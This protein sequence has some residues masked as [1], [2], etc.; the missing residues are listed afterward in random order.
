MDRYR[1]IASIVVLFIYLL[2]M[3]PLPTIIGA[4]VLIIAYV[5]ISNIGNNPARGIGR[6]IGKIPEAQE[7][8]RRNA[9]K[10]AKIYL[11]PYSDIW[12]NLKLSNKYCVLRLGSDGKTITARESVSPNRLLRVLQSHVY[13]YADL[14]DLFCTTFDHQTT[15]DRII[16]LCNTY[17]L[18]IDVQGNLALPNERV[19]MPKTTKKVENKIEK[20]EPQKE[21]LDVN[22]A[23]EVELT[24]L[25]GVSIVMAKKLIKKR[26]DINGFKSVEDV[27]L[28]LKLKP[29]MENQL[30]ELICVNKIKSSNKIK[31]YNERSVD[32]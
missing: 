3:Y 24:A 9:L 12:R 5:I 29:H 27:C 1:L 4:V 6:G 7:I 18:T 32:L 21:K 11:A 31:R 15:F 13:T 8:R 20:T 28:F 17:R 26:D 30:R 23:S 19:V 16:E 22:N 14:W 25:P 10:E 2:A